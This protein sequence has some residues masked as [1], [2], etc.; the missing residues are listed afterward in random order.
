MCNVVNLQVS[1]PTPQV[2][3][4]QPALYTARFF[5]DKSPHYL[6]I[7]NMKFFPFM[8]INK[9]FQDGVRQSDIHRARPKKGDC[10]EYLCRAGESIFLLLHQEDSYS[11]VE[12]EDKMA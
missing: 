8:N 2:I 4:T 3:R 6:Q 7:N 1:E 9:T 5:F 11:I 12:I 10:K